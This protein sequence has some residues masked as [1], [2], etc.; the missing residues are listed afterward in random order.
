M[1]DEYGSA[2]AL[3]I[4]IKNYC[5]VGFA[6]QNGRISYS[7]FLYFVTTFCPSGHDGYKNDRA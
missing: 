6:H 5:K 1:N 3:S 7:I 4:F 2:Y